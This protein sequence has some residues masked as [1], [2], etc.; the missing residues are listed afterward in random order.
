MGG[1]VVFV[2]AECGSGGRSWGCARA[3]RPGAQGTRE[4]LQSD[5]RSE[6]SRIMNGQLQENVHT[7]GGVPAFSPRRIASSDAASMPTTENPCPNLR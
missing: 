7:C 6:D 2:S 4:S 5:G 1:E 3:R